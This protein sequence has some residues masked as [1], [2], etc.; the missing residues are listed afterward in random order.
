MTGTNRWSSLRQY[1]VFLLDFERHLRRRFPAA[2]WE[3]SSLTEAHSPKLPSIYVITPT[4]ARPEQRAELT[5][6]R[7]TL[8]H[9]SKLKWIVVEDAVQPT[10]LVTQFLA[11]AGI[12]YIHLHAATPPKFKMRRSDPTWLLPKGAA[13]RNTALAWLRSHVDPEKVQAV[14]YFADD[15]NSY[16]L[17]VFD[18]VSAECTEEQSDKTLIFC[19]PINCPFVANPN[20][21]LIPPQIRTTKT[22]SVWPVGLVGGLMFEGPVVTDGKVSHFFTFYK[23]ERPFP[24]DMAGFAINARLIVSHPEANFSYDV[25]RGY[26]ESHFFRA[27]GVTLDHLEPRAKNCTKVSLCGRNGVRRSTVTP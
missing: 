18:E 5:R 6:L 22:V 15:D 3:I 13:Q 21:A 27:L 4:Y 1:E 25:P 26:Q 8:L 16:S 7:N 20:L 11:A 17:E 2:A 10:P 14:V 12:P 19:S 9:V 23:P 24:I